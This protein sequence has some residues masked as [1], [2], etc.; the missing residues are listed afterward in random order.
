LASVQVSGYVLN[1]RFSME[2]FYR[3]LSVD[4]EN[5]GFLFDADMSGLFLGAVIRF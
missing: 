5:D 1:D 2:F 4:Y 3:D